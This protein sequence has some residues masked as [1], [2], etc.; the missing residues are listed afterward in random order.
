MDRMDW[1]TARP[2]T[3]SRYPVHPAH[4][5]L[6]LLLLMLLLLVRYDEPLIGRGADA[7]A[8]LAVDRSGRDRSRSMDTRSSRSDRN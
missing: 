6:L 8:R 4:P 1:I 2:L 5:V 7:A 3:S